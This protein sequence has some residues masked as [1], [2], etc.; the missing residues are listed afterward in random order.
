M[1]VE[2]VLSRD[3]LKAVKVT[4]PD[5]RPF[6]SHKRHQRSRRYSPYGR[7]HT[8]QHMTQV[9]VESDLDKLLTETDDEIEDGEIY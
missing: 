1:L 8:R 7:P 5:G 9:D 4:G 2:Y 3:K 6:A